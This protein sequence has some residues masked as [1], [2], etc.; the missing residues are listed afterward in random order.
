[1]AESAGTPPW[2]GEEE[3]SRPTAKPAVSSDKAQDILAMIRSRQQN[4]VA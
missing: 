2:E 3:A 4:K 1:V